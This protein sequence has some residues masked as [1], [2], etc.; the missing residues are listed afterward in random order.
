MADINIPLSMDR[1]T[2]TRQ[3]VNN[4]RYPDAQFVR[5]L[6]QDSNQLFRWRTK[7]IGH[8]AIN[9][10]FIP[11]AAGT[12][13]RWRFSWH[14]SPLAK[15]VQFVMVVASARGSSA[16]P[17]ARLSLFSGTS[18]LIGTTD[19]HYG[20]SSGSPPDTPA[21]FGVSFGMFGTGNSLTTIPADTDLHGVLIDSDSRLVAAMVYEISCES[22]T[23]NGY[24]DDTIQAHSQI[25]DSLRQSLTEKLRTQWKRGASGLWNWCVDDETTPRTTTSL[26][27]KNA[28]DN[29]TSAMGASVPSFKLDLAHRSTDRR[30]TVPCVFKA[31][32]KQSSGSGGTIQLRRGDNTAIA[33]LTINSSTAGW[34]STTV[35]LAASEDTYAPYYASD[36]IQT[37]TL[38]ACSMYQYET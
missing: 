19:F 20:A 26:T 32:A 2:Q 6:V 9:P 27:F 30:V 25:L 31:Y 5:Y 36:G 38:Y 10:F 12:R 22:T 23:G 13:N 28:I 11:S 14:S 7:E 34:Y 16:D 8:F 17:Y 33:S 37:T 3:W 35:N 29:S 15:Y 24:V 21:Y 18:T 4:D 1:A